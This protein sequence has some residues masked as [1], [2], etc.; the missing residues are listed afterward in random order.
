M[1]RF[2]VLVVLLLVGVLAVS[3]APKFKIGLVFDLAGQG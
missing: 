1:K 3:A 2:T